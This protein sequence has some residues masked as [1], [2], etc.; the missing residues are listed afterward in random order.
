MGYYDCVLQECPSWPV[1][2]FAPHH[3][4]PFPRPHHRPRLWLGVWVYGGI[5]SALHEAQ[6][7][8]RFPGAMGGPP[9]RAGPRVGRPGAAPGLGD[10]GRGGMAS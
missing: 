7:V 5:P 4:L 10:P 3:F 9:S 6:W 1:P 8:A 2:I